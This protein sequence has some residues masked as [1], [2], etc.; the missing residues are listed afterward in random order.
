[1]TENYTSNTFICE[2]T[3]PAFACNVFDVFYEFRKT[4][5]IPA[6]CEFFKDNAPADVFFRV[7]RKIAD[8]EHNCKYIIIISF[9]FPTGANEKE[10]Q[11]T[12][13]NLL[14]KAWSYIESSYQGSKELTKKINDLLNTQGEP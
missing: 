12:V 3:G 7:E 5:I 8:M 11:V 6:L 10:G 2:K 4:D 13:N 1:M 14:E 9:Y